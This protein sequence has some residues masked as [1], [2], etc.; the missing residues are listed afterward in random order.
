MKR[1][2][3]VRIAKATRVL[4]AGLFLGVSLSVFVVAT[5]DAGVVVPNPGVSIVQCNITLTGTPATGTGTT[6]NTIGWSGTCTVAGMT[7]CLQ[8]AYIVFDVSGEWYE[9]EDA[10][11]CND[12]SPFT[13]GTAVGAAGAAACLDPGAPGGLGPYF[14]PCTIPS[15]DS[16]GHLASGF[17]SWAVGA[18][19][20]GIYYSQNTAHRSGTATLVT[21]FGS[22]PAPSPC[23]LVSISGN[24][25]SPTSNGTAVYN[26]T[27]NFSGGAQAIVANDDGTQTA[28]LIIGT[29]EPTV[30]GEAF[31]TDASLATSGSSF[32]GGIPIGTAW[33]VSGQISTPANIAVTFT[34]TATVD[35]DFLCWDNSTQGWVD[36]G[37]LSA[38][39]QSGLPYI[40]QNPISQPVVTGNGPTDYCAFDQ[41]T[42]SVDTSG[43]GYL[44]PVTWVEGGLLMA[45][46]LIFCLFVPTSSNVSALANTFGVSS[47]A[48]TS[49]VGVSGYL[50][51]MA[52]GVVSFPATEVS[53]ISSAAAGGGCSGD[54]AGTDTL[55]GHAISACTI[56]A[57]SSTFTG[58]GASAL[59]DVAL[60]L[61]VAVY[62]FA[63]V[64]LWHFF[65][66]IVS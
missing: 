7:P 53:A 63:A 46:G 37:L 3:S 40:G 11:V 29:T 51:A 61:S 9:M 34:S 4:L 66:K 14:G 45:K 54:L 17:M 49:S 23:S 6:D 27:V 38:L 28:E 2:A 24:T 13:V 56:L 42:A 33:G 5:A 22:T 52:K 15:H 58:G 31:A 55:D 19:S 47:N 21:A 1:R 18:V 10:N 43:W 57:A 25:S 50:G 39:G 26:Y 35:P 44:N 65:R 64:M 41:W 16:S 59:S 12:P 30:E 20:G 8:N 36:W 32:V 60:L 48:P 62:V